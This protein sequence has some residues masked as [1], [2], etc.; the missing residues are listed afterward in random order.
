MKFP[1]FLARIA[2][3]LFGIFKVALAAEYLSQHL[4]FQGAE[5][6][7]SGEAADNLPRGCQAG[8]LHVPQD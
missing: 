6:L 4:I 7:Q 2:Q 5:H 1:G 8:Q 3:N